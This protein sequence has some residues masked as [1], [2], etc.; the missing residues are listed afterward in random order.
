MTEPIT[1]STAAAA[2]STDE[3]GSMER[4]K[5]TK[6]RAK[7]VDKPTASSGRRAKAKDDRPTDETAAATA[8][9]TPL[10][11]PVAGRLELRQ[12]SLREAHAEAIDVQQGAIAHAQATDI[13]VSQ[14][15]V[16]LAR[17]ERVSV[18][19][20]ALGFAVSGQTRVSQG[21]VGR[22]LGRE[23][24]LEQGAIGSVLADHVTFGRTS[25]AAIV[26]ARRVDG[27]IRPLL[28]WRGALAVG[29]VAGLLI[30]LLRRR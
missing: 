2:A 11:P 27:E 26:I 1:D 9:A 13:A 22:L 19:M 30:G 29:A 5:V 20:G 28:D 25:G 23:V 3:A 16:G 15:A 8:G 7:T 18:E 14:G 21:V 4:P 17:G 10:E 6:A 12:D 24:H